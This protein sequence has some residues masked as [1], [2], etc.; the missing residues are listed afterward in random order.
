MKKFLAW[1]FFLL[2][3]SGAGFFF[4]WAHRGVPPDSYG[5]IRSKTHGIDQNLVKP[6]EFRW[7]W[8]KLIPTNAQTYVFRLDT[9]NRS[10]SAKDTLPSG[11]TYSIF[12]GMT[13]DFSWELNAVFSFSLDPEALIGL[14]TV[15]N[16]GTQEELDQYAAA[17]T[18]QVENYILRRMNSNE[19]VSNIE[20][21]LNN[22]E[23]K[24]VER[25]IL[26][27]FPQI[28]YFSLIV[29]S[30]KI[31]DFDVYAYARELYAEY[32]AMQKDFLTGDV[33]ERARAR[34][35]FFGRFG[36]LELY[37]ELI[38]RFPLLLNYLE[39]EYNRQ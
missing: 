6:G 23:D 5:V 28:S 8:Y 13:E 34:A 2:I 16:I 39:L 33:E 24:R 20:I 4:G 27:H 22:G 18:D 7:V 21:L 31:P 26:E 15:N 30:V 36:E 1:F 9:V 37:G 35:D 10:I 11:R 29:Q 17:I 25:E 3:L 38:T 32:I 19:F 12:A 14:V